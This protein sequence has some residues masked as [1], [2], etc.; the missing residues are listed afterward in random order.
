YVKSTPAAPA[1]FAG[2][3]SPAPKPGPNDKL[4]PDKVN[5]VLGLPL[6]SDTALWASP[7]AEV[8]GKLGLKRESET[9]VQSS[10]SAYPKPDA[11]LFGAH[12]YS[13]A[14]YADEGKVTSISMVFA[15]KGDLFGSKGSAEKHFDKDAP[16]AQ[17]AKLLAG[18]L[19]AD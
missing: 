2:F 6:F 19:K 10:F 3:S 13:I 7:A 8:A 9:K 1:P 5:D 12:P 14:L 15:N 18:A 4:P 17:R 16:P 11:K